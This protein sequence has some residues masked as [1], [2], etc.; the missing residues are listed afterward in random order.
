MKNI[1]LYV[2]LLISVF[3]VTG[4]KK[5]LE[6]KSKE[7]IIPKTAIDLR[8]LLLGNGYPQ[9]TS[10]YFHFLAMLDDDVQLNTASS[11]VGTT[12]IV[13]RFPV[14]TWQPNLYDNTYTLPGLSGSLTSYELLYGWIR[15][16]NAVLDYADDVTGTTEDVARV[17]AEAL[18]LRAFHYYYLINLYGVPYNKDKSAAGVPLKLVSGLTE[19]PIGRNTV[20]EVYHQMVKDLEEAISLFKA[21]SVTRND[22][23]INL[24]AACILLSRVYLYMGE[25]DRS[26]TSA[27]L[28]AERGGALTNLTGQNAPYFILDYNSSELAWNF[29]SQDVSFPPGFLPSPDLLSMYSEA[30]VRSKLFF[31]NDQTLPAKYSNDFTVSKF[32]KGM[33]TAEAYL[34][35]AEANAE[36]ALKGDAASLQAALSDLNLLRYNRIIGYSD[37][38]INDAN[39]LREEIRKERRKELC[40]EDHRWFDLRRYG[41]PEITHTYKASAGSSVV[42]FTLKQ[43]DP[44]YTLPI[45]DGM[46][47]NNKLLTQNPS[48][49]QAPRVGQ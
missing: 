25:W 1:I 43:N 17:K 46:F 16:C 9:A 38:I 19:N 15:G 4:C 31:N 34:N 47:N 11:Q 13:A 6:A 20:Q 36:K 44:Y 30:D 37:V 8:E 21:I 39:V 42:T 18:A 3:Q 48:R 40:F 33:R 22:F 41:M 28:A 14:Y 49:S 10:A 27:T 23:R 7:E 29:G 2:F 24:P 26:I 32:G 5:F 12:E 35:R 45:P